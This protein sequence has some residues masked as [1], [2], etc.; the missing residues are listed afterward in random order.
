M[1]SQ[2]APAKAFRSIGEVAELLDLPIHVLRFWEA[3]F[4]DFRP[5]RR[6]GGRR[7]YRREDIETLCGIRHLLHVEGYSI[8]GV[9]RLFRDKG[10]THIRDAC[11]NSEIS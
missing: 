1:L 11:R 2:E 3:R 7:V 9:Q 8:R 4:P 5:L 6:A 10:V